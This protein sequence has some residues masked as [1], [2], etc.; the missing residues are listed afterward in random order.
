M[1]PAREN[2]FRVDRITALGYQ[3]I[4]ATWAELLDHLEAM[5]F[6]G[7]V[8]GPCGSGKTTLLD[9]LAGHL[10]Q[11][12]LRVARLFFSVDV[13]PPRPEVTA[14]LEQPFDVL[15]LD[16]AD[17]LGLL[18]W[19]RIKNA[20][21]RRDRGLVITAHRPGRLP[22][23]ATCRTDAALLCRLVEWLLSADGPR[24]PAC[25]DR[26]VLEGLYRRH[27]GN[28]REALRRLYDIM[29]DGPDTS[30]VGPRP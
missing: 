22:T 20:V 28:I 6:C 24:A 8:V 25:P 17:H 16:G 30:A 13:R 12:G 11:R 26:A 4:E 2:P 19:R 15:L 10:T 18:A 27:N 7:A 21:L 29:A 14:V 23:W 3:P 1:R 9:T 5:H